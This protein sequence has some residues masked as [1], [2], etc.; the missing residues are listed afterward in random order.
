MHITSICDATLVERSTAAKEYYTHYDR[1]GTAEMGQYQNSG[2]RN[3]TLDIS[4][5]EHLG[6]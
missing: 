1:I 4:F 5:L 2:E 6:H 3:G